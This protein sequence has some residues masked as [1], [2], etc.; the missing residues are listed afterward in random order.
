MRR[1]CKSLIDKFK[2]EYIKSS[3]DKKY[4]YSVSIY[5]KQYRNFFY[6][7]ELYKAEF[8]DRILDQFEKKFIRL[9]C[10]GKNK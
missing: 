3:P 5:T 6:F 10:T 2:K 7:C 4:N 1:Q 9:E 8:S